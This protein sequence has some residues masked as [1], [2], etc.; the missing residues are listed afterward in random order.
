MKLRKEMEQKQTLEQ[1]KQSRLDRPSELVRRQS[2]VNTRSPLKLHAVIKLCLTVR[3]LAS[4]SR[5]LLDPEHKSSH[6]P[7]DS[8]SSQSEKFPFNPISQVCPN[9]TSTSALKVH[10]LTNPCPVLGSH[11]QAAGQTNNHVRDSGITS[12]PPLTHAH[13]EP[14]IVCSLPQ[15]DSTNCRQSIGSSSYNA[16]ESD[17]SSPELSTYSKYFPPPPTQVNSSRTNSTRTE[18]SSF[19]SAARMEQKFTQPHIHSSDSV[20]RKTK[21]DL[22]GYDSHQ[23]SSGKC[24]TLI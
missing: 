7:T 9:Q 20:R 5:E 11:V 19:S 4:I 13:S 10:T 6:R 16:N 21:T 12:N 1:D 24:C 2:S 8:V 15:S 3:E 18:Y 23:Q 22:I 17:H 14:L